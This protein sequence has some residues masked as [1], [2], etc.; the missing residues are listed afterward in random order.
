MRAAAENRA[1]QPQTADERDEHSR[2]G[3]D[4]VAEDEPQHPEPHDFW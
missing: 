3:L 1:P 4:R 2:D